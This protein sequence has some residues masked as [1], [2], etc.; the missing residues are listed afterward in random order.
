MIW[1][2]GKNGMLGSW[3]WCRTRPG[4][5]AVQERGVSHQ[6]QAAKMVCY[7]HRKGG[8]HLRVHNII[9]AA[10]SV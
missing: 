10:E 1:I 2:V 9:L 3:A 6:S 4:G 8:S 5:G 7:V